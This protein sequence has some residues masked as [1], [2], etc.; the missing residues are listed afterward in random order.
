MESKLI[1]NL[2]KY[3]FKMSSF[4]KILNRIM[5][6]NL[7]LAIVI[8]LITAVFTLSFNSEYADADYIFYGFKA[9]GMQYIVAFFRVYLIVN[10]FVPLDLLF[11]LELSKLIFTPVMERDAQMMVPEV[12]TKGIQG[13]KANTLNLSEELAQVEYIFCDKTGTLTQNE[14]VYR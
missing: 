11:M 14:L 4:E 3:V 12:T 8:A 1:M 13:L 2:G 10:S 7:L 9:G 5:V 6:L